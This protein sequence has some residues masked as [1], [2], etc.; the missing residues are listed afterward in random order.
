MAAQV[1]VLLL[2]VLGTALGAEMPAVWRDQPLRFEQ[3]HGQASPDV[4]FFARSAQ[5]A[6]LLNAHGAEMRTSAGRSISATL[7]GATASVALPLEPLRTKSNYFVGEPSGWHTD[8]ATY[9][10]VRYPRVYPGIELVYYGRDGVLEYDFLVSPGADPRRISW[11]IGGAEKLAISEQGDLT[12]GGVVFWKRPVLSQDG[13]PVEGHFVLHRNRTVSIA[14]GNYDHRRALV[15]DPVLSYSTYLGGTGNESASGIAVDS[16]G[17][18]VVVGFT[19]SM[20]FPVAR[21]PYQLGYGGGSTSLMTGDAFVAKYTPA[22]LAMFITYL[23]GL[24][25]DL[26]SAV[27]VDASNNIYLTGV[28][29]SRNFPTT[30]GVVQSTFAGSDGT[31]LIRLG[32]AFVTKLNAAGN[33]LIYSTYLGGRRDDSGTAIAVDTAGNAYVTGSTISTDFPVAGSALQS[34]GHGSGAQG[35]LP[36]FGTNLFVGGDAFVSKLNPAGTQLVY[37]TYLG[38]ANDDVGLGIA[39]DKSGNA[40]VTGDTL[41]SDFPVTAGAFQTANK[42]YDQRNTFFHLGDAFVAKLNP[43]GSA[44]VYSTFLGG[45]GDDVGKAIAVDSSGSAYVTGAT[46]SL[47]FPVSSGALARSNHGPFAVPAEEDSLIGDAF[48]TKLSADGKSLVYSTYL[49]GRR[50]DMGT[51]IAVDTAGNAYVAGMTASVE[52]PVTSDAAQKTFAGLGFQLP[53]QYLGDAF[54]SVLNTAGTGLLYSSYLGGKYDDAATA[55]ALDSSG[56]FY[57]AGTT[58]SPDFPTTSNALQPKF[59]GL[60]SSSSFFLGDAFVARFNGAAAGSTATLKAVTNAASNGTGVVSP[61]MVFVAYGSGIGPATLTSA[62]LTSAGLLSTNVGST[63][64]LFDGVPA[65]LVYVSDGQSSGIVPYSVAGKTTVTVT[66]EY[67]GVTGAPITLRVA[68]TVPALFSADYSGG[69]QAVAFNQDGS[70]NSAANPA[71]A[72]DILVLYGTGEGQTVPAGVDGQIA[73]S[74]YPKPIAPVSVAI[75]GLPADILYAGAVPSQVAGVLQVNVRIPAAVT[76]GMQPVVLTVGT[77]ASAQS[78]TVAVQ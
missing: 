32:D 58:I 47:D 37:S 78:L 29:N 8:Q 64:I 42:G 24:G 57:I 5:G 66:A 38:G 65:P 22:G 39:V 50:D 26:A 63:K 51:G 71:K 17:N 15:I 40:Y 69:G 77:T 31:A 11:R 13:H 6:L 60:D 36:R 18:I 49:G 19:T 21:S 74:V 12:A 30:P 10:R 28:T 4:Q 70:V 61:G 67:N 7:L 68:D 73:S 43:G 75:G 53:A 23:G 20:D 3:N 45:A 35:I 9:G 46:S 54:I 41:S 25:D 56:N 34:N 62:A 76:T 44:L 16:A 2:A 33:Q 59:A 14:T 52:F 72:G 48:V 1:A 55:V 27:A